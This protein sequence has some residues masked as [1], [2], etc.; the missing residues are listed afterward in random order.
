VT[1]PTWGQLAGWLVTAVA[2]PARGRATAVLGPGQPA[3]SCAFVHRPPHDLRLDLADG[4][5]V[6]AHR[7]FLITV[8]PDGHAAEG[9]HP[10]HV[11]LLEL[12]Q[13]DRRRWRRS[14]YHRPNGPVRE[15]QVGGRLAWQVLLEPPAGKVGPLELAIDDQTGR[16]LRQANLAPAQGW[17]TQLDHLEDAFPGD[18]EFVLHGLRPTDMA[19]RNEQLHRELAELQPTL[20]HI[21]RWPSGFRPAS[22]Q[23][24]DEHTVVV[25]LQLPNK[26]DRHQP[27]RVHLSRFRAGQPPRLPEAADQIISWQDANWSLRMAV[28]GRTLDAG[29]LQLVKGIVV[30]RQLR[31]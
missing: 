20:P 24:R 26:V 17:S 9:H 7:H 28:K 4:S 19:D 3:Q 18:E 14:D 5:T 10:L 29:E 15:T 13:D 27:V 11:A 2:A 6:L 8:A 16:M 12:L 21:W 1:P 22:V 31:P 23:R 25:T 30:E